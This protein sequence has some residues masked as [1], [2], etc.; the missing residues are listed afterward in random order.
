MPTASRN[1]PLRNFRFR[2]EIEGSPVAA[3]SDVSGFDASINLPEGDG[4][5][6]RKLPGVRKYSNLTLKKGVVSSADILNWIKT[7]SSSSG[8]V[9]RKSITIVLLDETG[10]DAAAWQAVNAWPMKYS[11]SELKGTGDETLL[12][13]LELACEGVTKT[14]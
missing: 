5:A 2:V 10:K 6:P 1:D 9:E 14:K 3:F 12:E 13:T 8:K 7:I 11:I 4:M